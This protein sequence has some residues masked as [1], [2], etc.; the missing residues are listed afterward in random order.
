MIQ[1]T[2]KATSMKFIKNQIL[3][4]LNALE[5]RISC[6]RS[7]RRS[8]IDQKQLMATYRQS[9]DLGCRPISIDD[10]GFRVHSQHEEDGH[11]LF[12]FA[13]IGTTNKKCVDIC[14]G[15]G[16]ECN[17][18]NLIIHHRWVGLLIDGDHNN[19]KDAKL[20]YSKNLN[21]HIWPPI[22][23]KKWITRDNINQFLSD[24]NFTGSV[25]LL[26][27]DID[28]IDYWV[29]EAISSID[30][31]VVVLEFNHLLGPDKSV[32]VPYQA[33]FQ[34]GLSEYG[35]DYAGASLQAFIKLGRKKGYRLVGT[36]SFA[37][38][39]YFIN[40]SIECSWL[41]EINAQDCFSHPRAQF[42]V[43]KRYQAIKD[44]EWVSV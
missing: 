33:D 22:I 5:L 12:I 10:V 24:A 44:K 41:P 19:V 39:A 16:V 43:T 32:S 23:K 29:W 1:I 38:N 2:R 15:N 7:S 13:L 27:L 36:N 26:S 3:K 42:G 30:P 28:G 17:T 34:A 8:S 31:R 25:D 14:A 35:S 21:T 6:R 4:I 37:T 40:D 11:L 20:Y 9:Y 18:A